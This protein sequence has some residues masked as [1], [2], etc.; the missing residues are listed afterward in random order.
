MSK[1]KKDLEDS[2]E[3]CCK[4][5]QRAEKLIG[6]LSGEQNSW[7]V[8]SNQLDVKL[9]QLPGDILLAASII[10]YLGTASEEYRKACSDAHFFTRVAH[11][12]FRVVHLDFTA[13]HLKLAGNDQKLE[14]SLQL[15]LFPFGMFDG[16]RQNQDLEYCRVAK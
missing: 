5:M 15:Q 1:R 16:S 10:S 11:L 4:K 8:S 7:R 3:Q 14:H 9:Q 6:G 12:H 2:I 13:V